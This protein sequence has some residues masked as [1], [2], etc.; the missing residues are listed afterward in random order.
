MMDIPGWRFIRFKWEMSDG[1]IK[2]REKILIFLYPKRSVVL[3]IRMHFFDCFEK[4]SKVF[5]ELFRRD[6]VGKWR[7]S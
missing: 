3:Y 2:N 4:K 1:R 7:S 5:L 6:S